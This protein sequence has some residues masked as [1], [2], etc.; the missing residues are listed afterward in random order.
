[1]NIFMKK[2]TP[3]SKLKLLRVFTIMV[4]IYPILPLLLLSF[5]GIA[6]LGI[7]PLLEMRTYTNL[8]PDAVINWLI[9]MIWFF[10]G[11]AGTIGLSKIA[12]NKR[13]PVSLFLISYGAISYSIIALFFIVGGIVNAGS[14]LL[15]VHAIYL[16]F[17]LCI[18][19][20]QII[21]T[22]KEVFKSEKAIFPSLNPK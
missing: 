12:S 5:G 2:T 10:G 4:F 9:M 1:M 16:V 19:T 7:S 8:K 11:I 15:L 6:V 13:T 18:I 17:T 20:I 14:F 22:T 3:E 21:M